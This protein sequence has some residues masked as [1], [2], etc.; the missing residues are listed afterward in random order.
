[1]TLGEKL[2]TL[3]KEKGWS[4]QLVAKQVGHSVM[5]ISYYES[6]KRT[7][8]IAT[9]ENFAKIFDVPY[10]ELF[11]LWMYEKNETNAQ[12]SHLIQDLTSHDLSDLIHIDFD[13]TEFDNIELD[14]ALDDELTTD[15]SHKNIPSNASPNQKSATLEDYAFSKYNEGEMLDLPYNETV[16]TSPLERMLLNSWRAADESTRRIVAFALHIENFEP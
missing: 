4:Q 5:S 10:S 12:A 16:L 1:M 6:G 2:K 7:P 13:D 14:D 9:L 8:N 11:I 3:R 15:V